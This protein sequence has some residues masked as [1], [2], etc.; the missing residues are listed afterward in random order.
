M[1]FNKIVKDGVTYEIDFPHNEIPGPMGPQGIPGPMGPSGPR[2]EK[3]DKGDPGQQGPPGLQGPV[4]PM[5]PPGPPGDGSGGAVDAYTKTETDAKLAEKADKEEVTQLN[6]DLSDLDGRKME[7][8]ILT[9]TGSAFAFD[10]QTLTFSEIKSLCLNNADFVYA[11][12][13][14][15]LYI[16]QY[17]SNS[18]IFFEASYISSD[19]PQMHRISINSANQVSQYNYDIAKKTEIP[20]ALPT[21]NA[22][23][24]TGGAT[25]TFDGSEPLNI[26]IPTGGGGDEEWEIATT[27]DV[28]NHSVFSTESTYD[29]GSIVSH[30]GQFWECITAVQTPGAFSQLNWKQITS[31]FVFDSNDNCVGF[32]LLFD[33]PY[34]NIIICI[35][36]ANN[37]DEITFPIVPSG[38]NYLNV[39]VNNNIAVAR[40]WR[41]AQFNCSQMQIHLNKMG[42]F[43]N[44]ILLK[45]NHANNN[46]S[47][48]NAGMTNYN[49]KDNIVVLDELITK[50]K[51]LSD[52]SWNAPYRVTVYGRLS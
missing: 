48:F 31:D 7:Y 45:L 34:K 39:F 13:S 46:N 11:L 42:K 50:L 36:N 15:R 24:F 25:G 8:K 47:Y 35:N 16:P 41:L 37:R 1:A 20:T 29:V 38:N 19:V 21:P 2:G 10:G 49:N 33:K 23:T 6:R 32:D 43:I 14:N 27:I 30:S 26:N 52:G 22:L 12:Y 40:I 5:G 3:G 18:N 4:G 17:V 44:L 9:F 51:V 28:P